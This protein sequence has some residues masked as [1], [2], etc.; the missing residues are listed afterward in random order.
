MALIG[1][2]QL[3]AASTLDLISL[4]DVNETIIQ[5]FSEGKMS[6]CTLGEVNFVR[7]FC[8]PVALM[9]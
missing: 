4:L 9:K 6:G 3:M 1:S 7:R 2:G 5:D 8:V